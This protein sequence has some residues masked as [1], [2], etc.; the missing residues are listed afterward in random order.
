MQSSDAATCRRRTARQLFP[1]SSQLQI[2]IRRESRLLCGFAISAATGLSAGK[3]KAQYLVYLGGTVEVDY[4]YVSLGRGNCQ[5]R[6]GCVHAI[7]S[8]RKCQH[9]DRLGRA[10]VPVLSSKM[11]WRRTLSVLSQLPVTSAWLPPTE[12]QRMLL[13]AESWAEGMLS[14]WPLGRSRARMTLSDPPEK[15]LHPS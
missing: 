14:T 7:A 13:I 11:Q 1:L 6:V 15:S 12:T 2:P 5:Q 4:A 9:S 8:L 10:Q 3:S